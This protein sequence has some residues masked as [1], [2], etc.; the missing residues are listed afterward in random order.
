VR[1]LNALIE[2]HSLKKFFTLT[3]DRDMIPFDRSTLEFV[4]AWDYIHSPWSKFRKRMKRRF[5]GFKFV[6]ILE[7]HKDKSYPHIHGF[8]NIWMD[9]KDWSSTWEG[10]RG[11]KVVW[12]EQVKSENLSEYVSKSLNVVKYVG[13][14]NLLDG[15]KQKG[16]HRT[17][18]RSEKLK[19]K[20]ELNSSDEWC[21]IKKAV[22][23]DEGDI[24]DFFAKKGIWENGKLKR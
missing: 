9:Q 13:K 14:E 19:A 23:D 10:C 5:A 20:F 6:A 8:T 11:G 15:Y 3:L 17:L 1:L 16:N 2:E 21:M 18:W 24:T 4:D 22:Y 7:A 12:V